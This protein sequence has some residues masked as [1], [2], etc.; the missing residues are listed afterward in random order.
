MEKIGFVLLIAATG[1]M[2]LFMLS[3]LVRCLWDAIGDGEYWLCFVTGTIIV[4]LLGAV[5]CV[6]PSFAC[7]IEST[8][9]GFA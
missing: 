6:W 5:L 9:A 1:A 8:W 7:W 2:V 3:L 4:L